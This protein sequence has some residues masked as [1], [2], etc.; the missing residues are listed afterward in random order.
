VLKLLQELIAKT[1]RLA[2]TQS[3]ATIGWVP[4]TGRKVLELQADDGGVF[5]DYLPKWNYTAVQIYLNRHWALFSK[6]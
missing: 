6:E 4:S 2:W 1:K 3:L 5:D